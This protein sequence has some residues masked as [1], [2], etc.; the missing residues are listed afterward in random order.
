MAHMTLGGEENLR[1]PEKERIVISIGP[2]ET[3]TEVQ[4]IPT[5]S[6]TKEEPS[7]PDQTMVMTCGVPPHA[8]VASQERGFVEVPIKTLDNTSTNPPKGDTCALL[9]HSMGNASF[10]HP[11]IEKIGSLEQGNNHTFTESASECP[12]REEFCNTPTA[13]HEIAVHNECEVDTKFGI[14]ASALPEEMEHSSTTNPDSNLECSQSQMVDSRPLDN[15][16]MGNASFLHPKIGSLEQGNDQ[17]FTESASECPPREE[18]CNTPTADH[19]IAVHNECKV[20]TKFGITASAL[21]E[22][23]ELAS[24]TN[25]E[26]NPECSQSQML[27]SRPL[28]N[29][30]MGNASFLDPKIEKIGSL[31]QGND[32]TFT[33]S[34]SEC[35]PR[36]EFCNT[37]TAD[38]DIAVHNEC[39]VDTKFGITASA[40]PE[41]MEHSSTTNPDSNLEC[42]QSQM[43]DSRPLDNHSMGNASFLHPKIG[44][45]EQGNDQ[46]FTESASEFPP[47]EEVCNTPTADHE[48]AFH[49]ECKVDT[50]F[51]ITASALP[52]EMELASTTNPESNPEC[53]QSQI[54]DS[55]PLDNHS[56]GNASFLDPKIEKIGSLEQGNDQTFTESASKCPPRE[57]FCNTPTADHEIA[58]HNE[59]KVDTKFGITASALPEEM[60]LASTTNPES[61]PECSQSQMLDSRP[62]DNHTMGNASFLDPKIEKIGSLEQ[63][64]DQTF[65]ESASECPPREE[66]C[67]TP[68]ADHDIAVHKEC[69]VDTKFGITASALPEEMEHSSTT[70]PDSNL[71]CS[72]SQMVDSRPLDNHSM[73]NASFLH[74]KIGSLEQGNDQTFTE[75]ASEFPPREEVCNTPTADHEIAFHNECKVDTKFGITASALPEEMELASTTN[76]ESNP[77]CSQSQMLDSR[78]LDNHSMGN[79]SFLDPKIEKIGSLEQGNDQTFTESASKCPPR[80]EFCNTPT[81]DHEI[82]VHNEC[83]VDTKF[84]ITASALPEEMERASTTNPDSNLECSQS[85]MLDS[86]PLDNHSMG[87]ASF[88]HPKIEKIGSLEQGNDQTFTESASECPLREEVCNTP[89]AD[90]EIAAHNECEVDTK[91]GITASALPEEMELASTTNPDSNP[92]CSQSQMLDSRPL[93]NHSMGNVSFLHPKIGSLEQGNDQT[94]TESAR[95][96]PP[97]EE[98]CNTPTAD[99]EINVHNE[100]EV[101]PKF[102]ITASALPEEMELASTTNP[103]RN[104]ECSQ[105][106]MLDSRPLDNQAKET[107]NLQASQTAH[108]QA[109]RPSDNQKAKL[110]YSTKQGME[111]NSTGTQEGS[112]LCSTAPELDSR[113]SDNQE[114]AAEHW[115]QS[116]TNQELGRTP[117]TKHERASNGSQKSQT[118][119]QSYHNDLEVYDCNAVENVDGNMHIEKLK[120]LTSEMPVTLKSTQKVDEQHFLE[121]ER[122]ALPDTR[123]KSPQVLP[124]LTVEDADAPSI[125]Q[126]KHRERDVFHSQEADPLNK[127]TKEAPA[128]RVKPPSSATESRS[129]YSAAILVTSIL[130][131]VLVFV[132]LL[133]ISYYRHQPVD[134]LAS[135][136]LDDFQAE[137]KQVQAHFPGQDQGLWLRVR[138][139]LQKHINSTHHLEPAILMFAAA[140]GGERTL[141]CLSE[142]VARAYASSLKSAVIGISGTSKAELDS[143]QAKLEVDEELSSGFQAG[144]R[145]AVVHRFEQLP[146]G[147]LLIFYKYC[148]H[149]NAAFKDVALVLTVLLN[150]GELTPGLDFREVEERVRDFL[151]SKFTQSSS[152]TAYNDMDVDKLSGLW[153][154]ISHLVLPV[155]PVERMEVEGCP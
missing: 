68:T 35:P 58:V 4:P 79:A 47:R 95:E 6:D 125:T 59:C 43:V 94:F 136:V 100:C 99:H 56:M 111:S 91:F 66:F 143:G 51:G 61:N 117:A 110:K 32:Q 114:E 26:S 151:W 103:D 105:I 139:F 70:N 20:D 50:K 93:D 10:P 11:K 119:Q 108:E 129:T 24:T 83:K 106:Q 53:S 98:F 150:S 48:I 141:K 18:V 123:T 55:R 122:K 63:G 77:E 9:K 133:C 85:Q 144:G 118:A 13:D 89:T 112:A 16:S 29:H 73:G 148:D 152:P 76:P 17:T 115:L 45:L 30:T 113:L 140:E 41:E 128:E 44:S 27:D 72:Q 12:P 57:E 49:N 15:H 1:P 131:A 78:P 124:C 107:M 64:N 121:Q 25:P 2:G 22:E 97:R 69:E 36:E 132:M 104:L 134:P 84:G 75:S 87:N 80:E 126:R 60:E 14:T 138:K 86:R 92:E 101:D 67:N 7:I 82:A 3:Q 116:K 120:H 88:L 8:L 135:T 52:E 28:D 142:R 155:Q 90:H 102:G 74:P 19:E 31:E 46:T 40:L 137:F 81:A 65:T 147:S 130:L 38:H 5:D 109:N 34:A 146:G 153:S 54:L 21:P 33:E 42:S 145:A 62:L 127:P 23:M 154:R 37:P 39:E 149:E 71:E 96:C